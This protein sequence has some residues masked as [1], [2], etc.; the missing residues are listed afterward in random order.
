MTTAARRLMLVLSGLAA[1]AGQALSRRVVLSRIPAAAQDDVREA[2]AGRGE[3]G[4][5]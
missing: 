1:A 3:G 2:R 4:G 5:K